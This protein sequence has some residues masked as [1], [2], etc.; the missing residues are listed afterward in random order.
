MTMASAGR[1]WKR[2][3]SVRP[4][5]R[6]KRHRIEREEARFDFAVLGRA[7]EN[8]KK[9]EIRDL[10]ADVF[11]ERTEV[12]VFPELPADSIVIDIRHPDE[13]ERHPLVLDAEK[14]RRIPFYRLSTAF[15]ELD[16]AT[17]YLLYCDKGV[18]SRLHAAH[19]MEQG[20][21]NVGVYRP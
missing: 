11:T 20:Y 21:G 13:E 16:T 15:R 3:I 7:I 10:A 6:A 19:L 2:V 14:V 9:V 5:T 18:M 4:T 1:S 8:C 17:R 12:T